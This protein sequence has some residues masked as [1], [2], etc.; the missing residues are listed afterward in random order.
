MGLWWGIVRTTITSCQ[1]IFLTADSYFHHPRLFVTMK[2]KNSL[3]TIYDINKEHANPS[4][5]FFQYANSGHILR[6]HSMKLYKPRVRL[7]VRKNFFSQRVGVWN[8]LPQHVVDA[9]SI[10]SFKNRLDD[11]WKDMDIKKHCITAHHSIS[12]RWG[13]IWRPVA[14]SL[15]E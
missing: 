10:N 11:H 3:L 4:Y 2:C 1:A 12:T 9:L 5:F 14:A 13:S 6:G 8:E 15:D 7:N